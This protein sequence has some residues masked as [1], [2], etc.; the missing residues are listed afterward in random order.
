MS[1]MYGQKELLGDSQCPSC[2]AKGRDRTGNH[3]QHW[4]NHENGD[5]WCSCNRCGHYVTITKENRAHYDNALKP[6]VELTPEQIQEALEE[7][8][9]LPIMELKSR[10]S[11]KAVAHRFA[12][13]PDFS[14]VGTALASMAQARAAMLNAE[15]NVALTPYKIQQRLS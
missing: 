14:D 12:F 7:V 9:E 4:K 3:L 10:A 11:T 13:R 8:S 6:H 15:Q 1:K 5:E 2:A